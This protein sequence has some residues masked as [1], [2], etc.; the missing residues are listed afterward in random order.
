MDANTQYTL[1]FDGAIRDQGQFGGGANIISNLGSFD[2]KAIAVGSTDGTLAQQDF[3]PSFTSTGAWQ[4]FSLSWDSTGKDLSQ[5]V[6]VAIGAA[7][8]HPTV[9]L[10]FLT[11]SVTLSSGPAPPPAPLSLVNGGFD[12]DGNLS[13]VVSSITGWQ[14]TNF[15]AGWQTGSPAPVA[16]PTSDPNVALLNSNRISR[17]FP[18]TELTSD[19]LMGSILPGTE[20]TLSFDAAIR[21]QGQFGGGQNI[22]NNLGPYSLIAELVGSVDGV[23]AS[24]DVA[25]LFTTVNNWHPASLVWDST[26]ATAAQ[27]V[28]LILR[29]ENTGNTDLQF[30]MDSVELTAREE[31]IPE[32][33]TMAM[34]GLAFTGLGGYLRR[35]RRC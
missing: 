5:N 8:T 9:S 17:G 15:N 14:L 31:V 35:R 21:D 27:D 25:P 23:L 1:S 24:T 29:A 2:L 33:A 19:P 22:I 16:P 34:L 30:V 26:G 6:T 28:R 12:D 7:D 18:G 13:G 20:Y 10:Q 4:N 3:A 32:P 11:D